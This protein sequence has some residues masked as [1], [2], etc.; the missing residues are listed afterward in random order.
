MKKFMNVKYCVIGAGHGGQALAA[1]LRYMGNTTVLYNRTKTVIDQI[2]AFGGI[3]LQGVINAMVKGVYATSNLKEAIDRSD[4]IMI[5]IPAHAHQDIAVKIAPFLK[6]RHKIVINP[7][8]TLGA[9]MFTKYLNEA[10]MNLDIPI[11]ET[12]TFILTSRK[13]RP[14][15]SQVFSR[16]NLVRVSGLTP[17]HTKVVHECLSYTFP[18]MQAAESVLITSLSN[19]GMI[20]HPFASLMNIGRIE[21]EDTYLHYKEGITPSIAKFLEKLD[22][23][24]VQLAGYFGYQLHSAHQWLEDVYGSTGSNLYDALQKTTQYDQISSPTD[25]NTRYVFEDIP[26]GIVPVLELAKLAGTPHKYLQLV[27]DL[28]N[29]LY[30]IDFREIGRWEVADFFETYKPK[31]KEEL[32]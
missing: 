13:T 29:E 27:L 5:C 14:G 31:D 1:Y 19:I 30:G 23:E 3:E 8:R 11:A 26:T 2:K 6:P 28:A 7:G 32:I 17:E 20:F 15:V 22:S 4:V 24:R 10:G 21:C 9:F 16:K 18:M 25:I 12:D